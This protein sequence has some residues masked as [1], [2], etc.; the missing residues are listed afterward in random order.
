M[1]NQA[2]NFTIEGRAGAVIKDIQR[3][4]MWEVSIPQITNILSDPSIA[5]LG[6]GGFQE[7][8]TCRAKSVAIPA[9]GLEIIESNFGAFKQFFPGK[10]TMDQEVAIVFEES[11]NGNLHSIMTEWQQKIFN[12]K[13][14]HSQMAGGKRGPAGTSY[15]LPNMY[16]TLKNYA[17]VAREKMIIYRNVWPKQVSNADMSYANNE[18]Q[19]F[20]VTFQYDLWFLGKANDTWIEM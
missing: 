2:N 19:T 11:E 18:S 13:S 3:S 1:A 9:R 4:W 20:T 10:F 5:Q 16:L 6:T 15:V 7:E 17:G 12:I 8:L 14:G